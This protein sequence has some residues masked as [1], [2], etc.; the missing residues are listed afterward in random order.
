MGAWCA[1]LSCQPPYPRFANRWVRW[2]DLDAGV[3]CTAFLEQDECVLGL[4]RDCSVEGG[5]REWRGHVDGRGEIELRALRA[6]ADAP[7]ARA[8][9]CCRGS[10]VRP[11]TGAAWSL[12][13]CEEGP[14]PSTETVGGLVGL[15]FEALVD[16]QPAGRF[17]DAFEAPGP[18][19]DAHEGY[20]LISGA[21][22][23]VDG[24]WRGA[25]DAVRIRAA[26]SGRFLVGAPGATPWL[27]GASE[28]TAPT[29]EIVR[30]PAE[31]TAATLTST[32][33][34][35]SVAGELWFVSR[36]GGANVAVRPA[37]GPVVGMAASPEDT[38]FVL[39]DG[40]PTLTITP[41]GQ[42][43]SEVSLASVLAGTP[44]FPTWLDGRLVFGGRCHSRTDSE[45]THCLYAYDPATDALTRAGV[46]DGVRLGPPV[47]GGEGRWWVPDRSGLVH[48][49]EP[50]SLRPVLANRFPVPAE[51]DL[52]VP[53]QAG[54]WWAFE[55]G[56]A[57]MWTLERTTGR[58]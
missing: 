8:P 45:R 30:L 37:P 56:G 49:V 15:Y 18:V 53:V 3:S 16:D 40:P 44:E 5:L 12:L 34:V 1:A 27:V 38:L 13:R 20:L 39:T 31:P 7:R 2:A 55:R 6:P 17:T 22:P 25:S 50:T 28:L 9:E 32:S 52:I 35:I 11:E 54:R 24:L 14:C 58:D 10:L 29:G 21:G 51:V 43:A 33:V 26:S 48:V 36:P 57:R 41:Q 23:S 19:I 47:R 42:P 46:P 4:F